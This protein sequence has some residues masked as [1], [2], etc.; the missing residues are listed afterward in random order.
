MFTSI[1][2]TMV[3]T[4]Q[5]STKDRLERKKYMG[6]WRRESELTA[7]MMSRFPSRE[8]RYMDKKSPKTK[9]CSS[10]SSERPRRRN[11]FD[12]PVWFPASMQLVCLLGKEAK[13]TF[14]EQP[15]GT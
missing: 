15:T 9:G 3:E 4:K 6:V 13:A 14:S 2:G 7:R 11:S 1:F 8:T 12:T 5:M 10:G